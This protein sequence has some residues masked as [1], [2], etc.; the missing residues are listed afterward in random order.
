MK[1][2]ILVGVLILTLLTVG[3]AKATN[4]SFPQPGD[5]NVGTPL[6]NFFGQ[7]FNLNTSWFIDPV[8]DVRNYSS[9][10]DAVSGIGSTPK[11]LMISSAQTVTTTVVFPSTM[12]VIVT[13]TGV[14]TKSGA[15]ALN[16]NGPF[17]AGLYRVF[18]GFSEGDVTFGAGS[19]KEVYPEWWGAKGD[20]V[21]DDGIAVQAAVNAASRLVIQFCPNKTYILGASLTNTVVTTGPSSATYRGI[22]ITSPI[23]I[24]IPVGTVIKITGRAGLTPFIFNN[25]S[26]GL[27]TGGG[28]IDG[29]KTGGING[30]WAVAIVNSSNVIV[31]KCEFQNFIY[32]P[33]RAQLSN[34]INVNNIYAHDLGDVSNSAYGVVF[35]G[36]TH[37]GVY[38][39]RIKNASWAG[40]AAVQNND[41]STIVPSQYI[42][43]ENNDIDSCG[44]VT[45]GVGGINI[46]VNVP[47]TTI[48]GGHISNCG[49]GDLIVG[50]GIVTLGG[51]N[52][53]RLKIL[54][55]NIVNTNGYG[56]RLSSGTTRAVVLGNTINGSTYS[57]ILVRQTSRS[58]ISNNDI[59]N[60]GA[61]AS[62]RYD[63]VTIDAGSSF[64]IITNNEGYDVRGTPY[65]GYAVNEVGGVG[66]TNNTITNNG[67][68]GN[69]LGDFNV[70]GLLPQAGSTLQTGI[71]VMHST[72]STHTINDARVKTNTQ[73][74]YQPTGAAG[75]KILGSPKNLY[76][77]T[78]T[79]G[80]SFV[81][82]TGDNTTI[83][84]SDTIF[85]YY[86]ILQ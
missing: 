29:N 67:G 52:N 11:T 71:F 32:S 35:Y 17:S 3:V 55:V 56:I 74:I 5:T 31:E 68:Y 12:N 10:A 53:P 48:S 40:L 46:D 45:G 86:L 70:Q 51:I 77:S 60:S 30:L 33:V 4:Y 8:V 22:V 80:V 39:S 6:R 49:S 72:E 9:I 24:N 57:G 81:A 1:R 2:A 44:T 69:V 19:V 34:Y 59:S 50:G 65:Q 85:I 73:V 27:F 41:G 16:I 15:G 26:Q 78:I 42:T 62:P 54:G 38:A 23:T 14:I 20:G 36:V 64:N 7:T 66:N 76:T 13:S 43:F 21:T 37:S 18:S 63:A 82:A 47:D 75:A 28:R 83:G 61:S 84:G 79:P 25:V 58:V